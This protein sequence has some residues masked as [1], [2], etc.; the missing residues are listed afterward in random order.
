MMPVPPLLF[1]ELVCHGM[2][3]LPPPEPL[4]APKPLPAAVPAPDTPVPPVPSSP[5]SLLP[6]GA[7]ALQ[8]AATAIVDVRQKMR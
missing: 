2:K 5:I 6:G 8:A 3:W 7:L 1:C 4:L